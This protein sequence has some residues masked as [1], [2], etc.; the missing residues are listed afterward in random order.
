MANWITGMVNNQGNPALG[1]KFHSSVLSQSPYAV[2]VT[3][4]DPFDADRTPVAVASV[5]GND[6]GAALALQASNT[7]LTI[8]TDSSEAIPLF[9]MA[10][11]KG[12]GYGQ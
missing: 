11:D 9:F 2:V 5:G 7:S 10:T 8:K 12:L 1:S 6:A 4:D 3:F